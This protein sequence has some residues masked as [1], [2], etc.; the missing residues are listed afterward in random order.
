M[1]A[2]TTLAL[3]AAALTAACTL[4]QLHRAFRDTQGVSVSAWLQ[5]LFLGTIWAT[6]GAATGQRVLLLSEGAFAL[7]SAAIAWRL[8]PPPRATASLLGCIGL[9]GTLYWLLGP[10]ACLILASIASLTARLAQIATSV[11]ARSAAGISVATWLLLAAS[12][13]LWAANGL[14][15]NDIVFAWSAATGALASLIVAVTCLT[16]R[17]PSRFG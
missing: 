6:Y 15:R 4:P 12:N 11:R 5:G 14:V 10:G 13:A 16:I 1:S 2:A 17:A 3:L 9:V 8:L 7:G